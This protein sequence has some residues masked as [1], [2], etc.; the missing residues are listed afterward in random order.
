MNDSRIRESVRKKYSRKKEC[1][2]KRVGLKK[3]KMM[4]KYMEK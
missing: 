3:I 2:N 1:V 4:S